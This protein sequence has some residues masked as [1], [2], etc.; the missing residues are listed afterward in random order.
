MTLTPPTK[1][2]RNNSSETSDLKFFFLVV[3]FL[4]LFT[5]VKCVAYQLSCIFYIGM[6]SSTVEPKCETEPVVVLTMDKEALIL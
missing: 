1:R 6:D 2:R 4:L 3:V 5:S